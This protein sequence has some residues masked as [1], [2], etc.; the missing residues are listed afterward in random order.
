MKRTLLFS[1]SLLAIAAMN[2]NADNVQQSVARKIEKTTVT[3]SPS[4]ASLMSIKSSKTLVNAKAVEA[5][6]VIEF[7]PQAT[8]TGASYEPLAM[9]VGINATN[10][11]TFPNGTIV[12]AYYPTIYMNT[13]P[14]FVKGKSTWEYDTWEGTENVTKTSTEDHLIVEYPFGNVGYPTLN[15]DGSTFKFG[16]WESQGQSGEGIV[17]AGGSVENRVEDGFYGVMNCNQTLG[18]GIGLVP[19]VD[20]ENEAFWQQLAKT[21]AAVNGFG[22]PVAYC[23]TPYALS[24]VYFPYLTEGAG[25]ENTNI[26]VVVRAIDEEGYISDEVIAEGRAMLKDAQ[27]YFLDGTKILGFGF[28][29]KNALGMEKQIFPTITSDVFIEWIM[30]DGVDISPILFTTNTEPTAYNIYTTYADGKLLPLNALQFEDGSS[31]FGSLLTLDIMYTW[32]KSIDGDYNFHAP[33]NGGSKTFGLDTYLYPNEDLWE[34]TDSQG[35]LDNWVSYS[36]NY[37]KSTGEVTLKFDVDELPS[38]MSGRYTHV[39]VSYPGASAVFTISQGD[40]TGVESVDSSALIVTVENGNFV[41][42]GSNA[43]AVEVYNVSGQKVAD[44]AV[45][46]ETVVDAQNLESGLYIL[47]FNDNKVVKIVK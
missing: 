31:V 4:R 44:A 18:E 3:P 6:Q 21:E 22:I 36:A 45:E 14:D 29:E 38:E 26:K 25:D 23:G 8:A 32:L 15:Y 7:A 35:A 34:Y 10:G 9:Y 42:K 2:V 27:P 39:T 17:M 12:P 5:S 16:T 13:T 30:P 47:K 37:D 20:G 40:A 43:S 33:D 28:Y 19:G 41:V 11:Y 24:A 46:G 1:A